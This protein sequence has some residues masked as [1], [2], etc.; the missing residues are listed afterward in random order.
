[1]PVRDRAGED[2]AA[3][4]VERVGRAGLVAMLLAHLVWDPALTLAGVAEF[5]VAEEDNP[6]VRDLL[7]VH[8]VVWLGAKGLVVGGVAALLHRLGA[9]REVAT[10]WAPWAIAALGVVAP[11]GW[12]AL[13]F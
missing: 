5:G 3:P 8:P 13:L 11:L 4:L 9:H 7:S 10:A 12:L 1:M 2:G 6:V